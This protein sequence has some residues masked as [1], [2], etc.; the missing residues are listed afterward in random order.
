[1]IYRIVV[2]V[3]VALAWVGLVYLPLNT[4][5]IHPAA[6]HGRTMLLVGASPHAFTRLIVS[7]LVLGVVTAGSQLLTTT[8]L[9]KR[10]KTSPDKPDGS[11]DGQWPPAPKSPQP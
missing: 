5:I 9:R 11:I 4:R 10:A 7:L 2:F 3:L 8:W 6:L 1:M